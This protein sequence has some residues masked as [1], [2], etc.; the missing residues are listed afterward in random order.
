MQG[1]T[2]RKDWS[3]KKRD[4]TPK[5]EEKEEKLGFKEGG[6]VQEGQNESLKRQW[7]DFRERR[8]ER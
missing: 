7:N 8:E 6:Q 5:E 2:Q 4:Y 3:P 1:K